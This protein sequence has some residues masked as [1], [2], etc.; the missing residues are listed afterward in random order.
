MG[1]AGDPGA[2]KG[3]LGGGDGE[4]PV[5]RKC[6]VGPGEYAGEFGHVD[7]IDGGGD[8]RAAA[9]EIA[10]FTCTRVRCIMSRA[11]GKR[12]SQ[13]IQNRR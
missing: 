8:P 2:Y 12:P 5:P 13:D 3:D 7:M 10:A 9:V 1:D 11:H 6:D 4:V